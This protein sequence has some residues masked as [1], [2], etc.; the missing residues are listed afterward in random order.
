MSNGAADGVL[1]VG[2]RGAQ[3]RLAARAA[4]DSVSA[5]LAVPMVYLLALG[6]DAL[7]LSLYQAAVS[8]TI[9]AQFAG[10]ALM[11]RVR[12]VRLM[13]H[14]DGLQ[15]ICWIVAAIVPLVVASETV[16]LYL[17]V[18][19]LLGAAAFL[20]VSATC[21]WPVLQDNVPEQKA[22]RF[23]STMRTLASLS[24][25]VTLLFTGAYL[26]TR[27]DPRPFIPLLLL[28]G[29]LLMSRW[30]LLRAV[31]ERWT[32]RPADLKGVFE[33]F[34]L[35]LED[36]AFRAA[37]I[38]TALLYGSVLSIVPPIFNS[39]LK[40]LGYT[41]GDIVYATAAGMFGG[42]LT[43]W[44]W[45]RP[46]DRYGTRWLLTPGMVLVAALVA[47]K[48]FIPPCPAGERN[49]A[50]LALIYGISFLDG[51]FFIAGLR[52]VVTKVHWRVTQPAWQGESFVLIALGHSVLGLVLAPVAGLAVRQIEAAGLALPGAPHGGYA[53]VLLA[54]ALLMVGALFLRKRLPGYFEERSFLRL[55]F[56]RAPS[57]AP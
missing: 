4:V 7:T 48:A 2:S 21:W 29:V 3:A 11:G 49:L 15:G 46:V 22:A 12:K 52:L 50:G 6:A 17:V 56:G 23:F 31:P 43:L 38:I 40:A 26:G 32:P 27:R 25:F 44:L 1:T 36:R 37:F 30:A 10:L 24:A 16:R 8:A 20:Q 47:A 14:T 9:L 57:A 28:A 39:Y 55:A 33:R 19:A 41:L 51:A 5:G 34:R 13:N 45:A 42:V 35:A 18:G 53:L 54:V